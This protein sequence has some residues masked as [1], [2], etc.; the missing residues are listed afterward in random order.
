MK[1]KTFIGIDIGGTKI[2]IGKVRDGKIDNEISLATPSTE[3]AENVLRDIVFGIQ[4]MMD[5]DVEGIGIG[6]PGLVDEE[7]GIVYGVQN[8]PS[9]NKVHLKKHIED[10]FNKKVYIT[11]DANCFAVGEK[12]FGKGRN[13]ENFVGLVLGTGVGAGII[14]NGN[15]YSGNLCIAGEFGGI[16]YLQYDFENY[17]SNKFFTRFFDLQGHEV[18]KMAIEGD[19]QAKNIFEQFAKHLSS[20]IQAILY[21]VGPEAIILGGSISKSYCFIQNALWDELQKFPHK[22][23]LDQLVIEVSEIEKIAVLGAAALFQIKNATQ[24]KKAGSLE[25]Q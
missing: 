4:Q 18:F 17:C 15:L 2:C 19:R 3:S 22:R 11:N 6:V 16:P 8:I 21:S 9:W 13:F 23:I 20:L 10:Q 7:N 25:I 5:D 12:M 24:L 1:D 14:I